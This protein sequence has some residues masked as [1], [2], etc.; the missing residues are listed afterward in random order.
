MRHSGIILLVL[1]FLVGCKSS[2]VTK[3]AAPEEYSEELGHLRPDLSAE[4][5]EDTVSTTFVV[6]NS[7][8]AG[9]LKDE[10]DS[11]NRVIVANNQAQRYIDGYTIQIYTGN[12]R[13]AANEARHKAILMDP[14]LDPAISYHQPGYKVK[15]GEYADRLEAHAVYTSLKEEFPLAL[16]IPERIQVNYD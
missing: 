12:D 14:S 11:I 4:P 7:R 10:L 8:Y 5:A 1:A 9:G 15:V 6:E 3:K 13:D 16:L 2:Q